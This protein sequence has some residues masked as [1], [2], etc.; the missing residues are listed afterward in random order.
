MSDILNFGGLETHCHKHPKIKL[1]P[2]TFLDG[3][4]TGNKICLVCC[5]IQERKVI[6]EKHTGKIPNLWPKNLF[7]Y[8]K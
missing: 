1:S 6:F 2:L 8:L 5:N 7:K 4:M 3:T